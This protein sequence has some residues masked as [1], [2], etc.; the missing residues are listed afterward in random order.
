MP[1]EQFE[2]GVVAP[3]PSGAMQKQQRQPV[4]ALPNVERNPRQSDG[5]HD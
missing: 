2:E 3:E 5:G 1:A 4:T